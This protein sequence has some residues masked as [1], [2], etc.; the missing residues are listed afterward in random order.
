MKAVLYLNHPYKNPLIGW[1]HEIELLTVD[2]AKQWYQ[3]YYA[4]NNAILIVSGDVTEQELRPLAERYYGKIKAKDI[5]KRKIIREPKHIS[6]V[7]IT[8][9]DDKVIKTQW[10]RYYLAP[11]QNTKDA[12]LCYALIVLSYVL[13]GGD[14][15]RLYQNL[16]VD[17]SIAATVGSYYDDLQIGE[18][19]FGIYATAANNIENDT[20]SAAIEKEIENIKTRSITAD[21][22]ERAKNAIIADT[23]YAKEDLKT[24]AYLYGQIIASGVDINYAENWENNINSVTVEQINKAANLV[25]KPEN[26]VTGIL[27]KNNKKALVE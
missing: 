16:V 13:G 22:L 3:T 26:S 8:L 9:S 19:I 7:S 27:L 24:L 2:D 11:S 4:P 21:E 15:S 10:V 25:L 12:D 1:R 18:A 5:P 17:K 20:V 14:T 6:P 23:I